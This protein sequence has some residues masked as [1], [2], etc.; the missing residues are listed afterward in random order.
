MADSNLKK[1]ARLRVTV[2]A[3]DETAILGLK[4]LTDY[5]PHN[6]DVTTAKLVAKQTERSSA[7]ADELDLERKLAAARD[8]TAALEHEVHDGVVIMREQ[9][10]AQYGK[11]SDQAVAVGLKKKSEYRR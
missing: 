11:S 4:T 6:T 5:V 9:V 7:Y 10:V 8:R 1:R 3:D 2:V